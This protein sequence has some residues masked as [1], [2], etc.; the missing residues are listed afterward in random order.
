M[1]DGEGELTIVSV[2]VDGLRAEDTRNVD[3]WTVIDVRVSAGKLEAPLLLGVT[4]GFSVGDSVEETSGVAIVGMKVI[5][6]SLIGDGLVITSIS[7]GCI[8]RCSKTQQ[9]GGYSAQ[10]PGAKELVA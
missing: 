4:A 2:E 10:L 1:D 5:V 9:L 3:V 6:G 7:V 8:Y